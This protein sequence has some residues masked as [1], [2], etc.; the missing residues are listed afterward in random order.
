MKN[1]Y[2][3]L[4]PV[5]LMSFL[6]IGSVSAI[7]VEVTYVGLNP[8]SETED[9]PSLT[10]C[11]FGGIC[12]WVNYCDVGEGAIEPETY[13]VEPA[14]VDLY[15][16]DIAE[17]IVIEP[18][19]TIEIITSREGKETFEVGYDCYH[20]PG[21]YWSLCKQVEH[22]VSWFEKKDF[23]RLIYCYPNGIDNWICRFIA[24]VRFPKA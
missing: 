20:Q 4:I 21:V 7:T 8:Q 9:I 14:P 13:I 1:K 10:E 19:S 23:S 15:V 5:L 6:L 11:C 12:R 2:K 3:L 17:D 16:G 24:W 18:I 22:K